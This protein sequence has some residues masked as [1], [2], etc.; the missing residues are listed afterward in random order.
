LLRSVY[1]EHLRRIVD[2]NAGIYARIDDGFHRE[3]RYHRLVGNHD[4]VYL[5]E[6]MVA[7]LGE[8]HEGLEVVDFLVFDDDATQPAVAVGIATHGHHVDGWN[9]PWMSGLGKLGTWMG[10]AL[11][12]APLVDNPG[13]PA[14]SETDTLLGGRLP[15][16]LTRVNRWLGANLDLYSVDE[17]LLFDAF[18]AHGGHPVGAAI[19]D[20]PLLLLGH[21]HL[22]LSRPVEPATRASWERYFNSGS[23]IY[24]EC[25]TGLEWDGSTDP[26]APEVRLVA[27]RYADRD[28]EIDPASIVAWDGDRAVVREVLDRIEPGET[29]GVV[30][31]GPS[32]SPVAVA[33]GSPPPR[34]IP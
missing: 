24:F 33:A 3:G 7:A 14:P 21:T 16:V 22:P 9:A 1:V 13:M 2:N 19:E 8:V 23:G 32:L 11:L 20:G 26:A 28:D 31:A 27:W 4:D 6:A 5:D 15:D 12:D 30:A 17:V 29:L 18:R 25:I 10:A 34:E